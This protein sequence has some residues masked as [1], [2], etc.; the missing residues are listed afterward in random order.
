MRRVILRKEVNRIIRKITVS[1]KS[2]DSHLTNARELNNLL[3]QEAQR[4]DN[5]WLWGETVHKFVTVLFF[6][7]LSL[8]RLQIVAFFYL[9]NKETVL[10][11]G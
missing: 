4:F 7:F 6:F 3:M 10:V 8:L 2:E 9:L 5:Q 1:A 11:L